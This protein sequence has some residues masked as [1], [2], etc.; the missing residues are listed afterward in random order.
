MYYR[1]ND[2]CKDDGERFG[3]LRKKTKSTWLEAFW[4]AVVATG[5]LVVGSWL[6]RCT[7]CVPSLLVSVKQSEAR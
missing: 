2:C 1:R 4:A 5:V 6:E 7:S 3:S